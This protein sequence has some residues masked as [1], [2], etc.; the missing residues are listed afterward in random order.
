MH[1]VEIRKILKHVST[2]WLSLVK[3]L[4]TLLNQWKPLLSFLLSESKRCDKQSPFLA[5]AVKTAA[6]VGTK[7]GWMVGESSSFLVACQIPKTAATLEE[8]RSTDGGMPAHLK[9]KWSNPVP[10][11]QKPRLQPRSVFFT[12]CHQNWTGHMAF[13]WSVMPLFDQTNCLLQE[14]ADQVYILR[15]AQTQFLED[16]LIRFIQLGALKGCP[17]LLAVAYASLKI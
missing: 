10:L 13:F 16:F 11:A 7:N 9:R 15:C 5:S 6:A 3:Y 8:K 4:K 1:N 2:C 14:Q 17:L 12:F